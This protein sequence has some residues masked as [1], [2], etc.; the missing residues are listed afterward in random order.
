MQA[1]IFDPLWDK[2]V[3]EDL[4][5][6]LK[7]AG[8]ETIITKEI[9][10]LTDCRALY[11]GGEERLLCVNPDYVNWRLTP[12]HYK[13]IPNLKG[14]FGAATSF[15]WIDSSYAD[16][17][18]IPICNIRGFS[19]E[20][21]AEWATMMMLNVA[22]QTPRLIKDGFPLD[23][24]RDYMKYRGIE[25]HD[26]T[27]GII[28]LGN[29]GKAIAKRCAGLG[30]SV[31]YWSQNSRV[32]DYTYEELPSLLREAD[33]IFPVLAVNDETKKLVTPEL[34]G[35]IK[36]SA[37]VI[38][39]VNELFE[40]EPLI[41][42]VKAGTLYGLGFEAQPGVFNEYE[43]NVWAAPAYGWV[44]DNSMYGTEEKWVENMVCATRGEFPNRV[45]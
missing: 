7:N 41:E 1:F 38:D 33:V 42:R 30:M 32:N 44:T 6:R 17:K 40:H 36:S 12:D 35:T 19:S 24:D 31:M 26:K 23:F 2:L 10:P 22:R 20:A 4:K 15:S 8:I 3:T 45:N 18:G 25:V 43:G 34:L 27:A 13:D 9:A 29:I 5:N 28:G 11:E 37:M 16:E 14:I 39:I 21:V